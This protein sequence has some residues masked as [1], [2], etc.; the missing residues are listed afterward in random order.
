MTQTH[1]SQTD[2]TLRTSSKSVGS[3]IRLH[4]QT[5]L[6]TPHSS[7]HRPSSFV[8]FPFGIGHRSCIG[9]H[10][11]LVTKRLLTLMSQCLWY[12]SL[13]M[14]AKMILARLTQTFTL[15]LPPDYELVKI[16]RATI[17]PKGTVP[18]TLKLNSN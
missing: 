7:T 13:Q 2:S 8:F 3:Y 9:K 1:L 15:S 6:L 14:E 11:A 5:L 10:F 4:V 18:C 16:Q 12:V 17:Q